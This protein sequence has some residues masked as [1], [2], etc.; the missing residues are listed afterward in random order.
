MWL[1]LTLRRKEK[2][3]RS[4]PR[5]D[6]GK[7]PTSS[8]LYRRFVFA[9]S[10]IVT[11]CAATSTS[12]KSVLLSVVS[13]MTVEKE[14]RSMLSDIRPRRT[15][16]ALCVIGRCRSEEKIIGGIR[17]NGRCGGSRNLD[18]AGLAL[19]KLA[20]FVSS[21]DSFG[22]ITAK[23][24]PRE[25]SSFLFSSFGLLLSRFQQNVEV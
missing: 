16:S 21:P 9:V 7:Q 1:R 5:R 12:K 10:V 4:E 13:I 24:I 8:A 18:R 11:R 14:E 22:R 17:Q 23:L 2:N 25:S 3:E 6:G 15:L 19:S 20:L